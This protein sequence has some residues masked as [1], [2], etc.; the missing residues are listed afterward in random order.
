MTIP[1]GSQ[2]RCSP[3]PALCT[4]SLVVTVSPSLEAVGELGT[5]KDKR[6]QDF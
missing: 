6:D 3:G 2:A 5:G 1:A 4:C